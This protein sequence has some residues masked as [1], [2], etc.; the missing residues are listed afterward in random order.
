MRSNKLLIIAYYFPS[1]AEVGVVR[2]AKFAKYLKKE[3]RDIT[4]LTVKEKYYQTTNDSYSQ[5]VEGIKTIRTSRVP[6]ILPGINEE[7]FYW[8]PALFF[9]LVYQM[10]FNRPEVVYLTGGPFYHWILA[11]FIKLFGVEYILDFR[12]PW[13]LSPYVVRKNGFFGSLTSRL[14]TF[15]ERFAIKYA[16][17]VINVTN[18]ATEMYRAEYPEFSEKFVTITNG[19]DPDDFTDIEALTVSKFDIVYSGKFGTFRDVRPFFE[20][21][22]K[23]I[24]EN[25]LS[26]DDIRFVWVGREEKHI[27]ESI[28]RIELENYV[29]M[30]GFLPYKE[31]LRY[32][33]GSKIALLIAGEHPY[34][35]TTKIFD[36]MALQ[37]NVLG[38]TDADGFVSETLT[39]YPLG[40]HSN[41]STDNIY[42]KI[43]EE[44]RSS[45]KDTEV[46]IR[47][48]LKFD[49][50]T[51]T[52][53]LKKL[54][55]K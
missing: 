7:G 8:A 9:Y 43:Q 19:F 46:E 30:L 1:F 5:D 49:R 6:T 18:Q 25:Q 45:I 28:K 54:I 53:Q 41:N 26:P 48:L 42:E 40:K 39:A 36:Y 15:I 20:A 27:V 47:D 52:L 13:K 10:L 4:V 38:V 55:G 31:N 2:V 17:T 11:P 51:L 32:I 44:F 34:E 35:P 3:G 12:D 21:F 14:E 37:K 24:E 29:S 33:K 16:K 22:K 23:I 50:R